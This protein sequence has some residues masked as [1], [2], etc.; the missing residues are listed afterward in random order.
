MSKS[1]CIGLILSLSVLCP[2]GTSAEVYTWEDAHVIHFTDDPSA[3][4][5]RLIEKTN[6]V[7]SGQN[8]NAD[9]AEDS[10]ATEQSRPALFQKRQ[11]VEHRGEPGQQRRAAPTT[12]QKPPTAAAGHAELGN[13]T[14]PSLATLMVV[15]MLLVLILM[16]VWVVT[17]ISIVKSGFISPTI[18]RVWLLLVI[19]VPFIGMIFYY[20]LGTSQKCRL[21]G[22]N[23]KQQVYSA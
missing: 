21:P 5:G 17:I 9:P 16:T 23:D 1:C 13:E 7:D 22:Y 15:W 2:S 19:F 18:K 6:P 10:G 20:I 3:V 12:A 14:F 11:D 4:P 8:N